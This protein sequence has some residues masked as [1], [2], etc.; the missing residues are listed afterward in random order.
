M[1]PHAGTATK[2]WREVVEL[3]EI[4]ERLEPVAGTTVAADVALVF[5]WQ[6]GWALDAPSHPSVDVAYIDQV[7]SMY[8]ALW[9]SGVTVDLIP[10]GADLSGYRLVVLPS[11]YMAGAAVGSRVEE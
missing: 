5:D 3:G 2:V 8:R 10:P 4:L 7:L 9:E 1:A 6:S 11:L